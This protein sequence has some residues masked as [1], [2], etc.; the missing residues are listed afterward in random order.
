MNM[1]KLTG[2]EITPELER[3]ISGT[4]E[5]A[6]FVMKQKDPVPVVLTTPA[7]D[8]TTDQPDQPKTVA[9]PIQQSA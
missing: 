5:A 1:I 7:P 9:D 8:I 3:V 2:R 4:A 6:V